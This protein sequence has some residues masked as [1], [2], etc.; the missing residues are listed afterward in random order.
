MLWIKAFHIIGVVVWFAGLF[1]LIRL[2]V[3]HASEK[4]PA[5]LR[6][7]EV[8]ER[9]LYYAITVPGAWLTVGTGAGLLAYAWEA[10]RTQGWLHAKMAL[11]LIL[12]GI[13]LYA[14]HFRKRFLRGGEIPSPVFFR[15]LNE[16]PTV[17]LIAIVILVVVKPF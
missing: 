5:V 11:V 1:Y 8:M 6:R 16:A 17:L 12:L 4:E 13:H 7:F 10:F 14:G 9:R 15:I 2:Y 3:Y